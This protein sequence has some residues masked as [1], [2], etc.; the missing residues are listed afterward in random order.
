MLSCCFIVVQRKQDSL[1]EFSLRI[2][3]LFPVETTFF[4]NVMESPNFFLAAAEAVM[5]QSC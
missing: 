2:C 3:I 5:T 1:Q 4:D